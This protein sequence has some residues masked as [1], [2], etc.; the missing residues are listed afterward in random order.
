MFRYWPLFD[1]NLRSVSEANIIA[2]KKA[3]SAAGIVHKAVG[4]NGALE[5]TKRWRSSCEAVGIQQYEPPKTQR[6]SKGEKGEIA[7]VSDMAI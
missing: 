7:I 4:K 5:S 6:Q 1:R 3:A 2:T